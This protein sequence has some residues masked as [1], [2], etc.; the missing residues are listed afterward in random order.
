MTLTHNSTPCWTI[1]T[2]SSVVQITQ[3]LFLK[4]VWATAW[5]LNPDLYTAWPPH[6]YNRDRKLLVAGKWAEGFKGHRGQAQNDAPNRTAAK[7]VVVFPVQTIRP[8]YQSA[9]WLTDYRNNY[10]HN[11]LVWRGEE[12]VG[13]LATIFPPGSLQTCVTADRK[14]VV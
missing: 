7:K 5:P 6:P 4:P 8:Q 2:S 14:S 9:I 10:C 3:H 1:A 12:V 13:V 11:E